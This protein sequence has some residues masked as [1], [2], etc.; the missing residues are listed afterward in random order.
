MHRNAELYFNDGWFV[1]SSEG[2]GVTLVFKWLV[3]KESC[4]EGL[5]GRFV[6]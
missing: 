6:Y 2:F 1:I 5:R 3:V 4:V